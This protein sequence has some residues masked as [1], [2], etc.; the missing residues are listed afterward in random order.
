[1]RKTVTVLVAIGALLGASA[2]WASSRSVREG[3]ARLAR[4]LEGRTAGE[5]VDC[6][7][8]TNNLA[9]LIVIDQVGLVYD[10][11]ETLYVARAAE[12]GKLRRT[13]RLEFARSKGDE[14]C[15]TDKAFMVDRASG[16]Q[17]S[18]IRFDGFV[19]YTKDG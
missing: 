17:S 18:V 8:T 1:M 5:R 14:L 15:V 10:T 4:M 19:P 2:G 13:D 6:V 11:G 3:E 7:A 12:P 16:L 9:R